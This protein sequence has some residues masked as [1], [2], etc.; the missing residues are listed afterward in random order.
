MSDRAQIR[1]AD[2][3]GRQTDAAQ[4]PGTLEKMSAMMIDAAKGHSGRIAIRPML[5]TGRAKNTSA[6]TQGIA[7]GAGFRRTAG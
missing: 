2:Q 1:P 3:D 5:F 7:G 4:T 6:R